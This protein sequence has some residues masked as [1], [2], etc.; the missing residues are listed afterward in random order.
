MGHLSVIQKDDEALSHFMQSSAA[1]EATEAVW[2][3]GCKGAAHTSRPNKM[4]FAC[5]F[6]C[7]TKAVEHKK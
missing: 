4:K 6:S 1:F 3:R 7:Y 2:V 5:D